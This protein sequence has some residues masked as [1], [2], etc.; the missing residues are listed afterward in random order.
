MLYAAYFSASPC[1][2][3]HL[4]LIKLDSSSCDY[5][6]P[7]FRSVTVLRRHW[8]CCLGVQHAHP[9]PP[10]ILKL[11]PAS[12]VTHIVKE[13]KWQNYKLTACLDKI[14]DMVSDIE[15]ETAQIGYGRKTEELSAVNKQEEQGVKQTTTVN[16]I[17]NNP[18]HQ[19]RTHVSPQL[20]FSYSQ[21]HTGG[22]TSK[23]LVK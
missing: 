4:C 16:A 17:T 8:D 20:V 13:S 21:A 19:S 23:F 2:P 18:L 9:A 7:P 1:K 10:M 12:L 6:P 11:N 15:K 22:R 5:P 3:F 14:A